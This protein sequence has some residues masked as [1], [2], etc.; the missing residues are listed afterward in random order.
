MSPFSFSRSAIR[1]AFCLFLI[2]LPLLTAW[3]LS[4]A[5]YDPKLAVKIGPRLYGVT[6]PNMIEWSLSSLMD[7]SLRK[8]ITTR[9]TEALPIRPLLVRLNNETRYALFGEVTAPGIARGANGQLVEQPYLD[10][11]CARTEDMAETRARAIIPTLK[12]IQDYY[13][14]HGAAFFYVITP[15]KVAHMPEYFINAAPCHSTVAART[16]MIPRYASLLKN[17]GI[18]VL[19]LA[20]FTHSLKGTYKFD[21]FPQGGVH[22][23]NVGAARAATMISEEINRQ[24]GQLLVPPFKFTYTLSSVT[25]GVDR[26]LADLMNVFFP[27][28]G[29]QTPKVT[30]EKSASCAT[31]PARSLDVA[32]V[33][34]SFSSLPAEYLI[35]ENCLTSLNLYFYLMAGRDGG[36]PYHRLQS[37]LVDSDITRLRDVRVMIVE[38]NESVAGTTGYVGKLLSILSSPK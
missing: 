15:S 22:W 38:E 12:N 20:T 30:F 14:S 28:L 37:N 9:V 17:A 7:G 27:Q 32:I 11:Y 13:R 24:A 3:N 8:S 10:E 25:S 4:V 23:N 36:D 5:S 21:L 18:E 6:Q 16:Q 26:E 34:S 2:V 33:G 1:T 19:D 35:R 29:Y 31:H